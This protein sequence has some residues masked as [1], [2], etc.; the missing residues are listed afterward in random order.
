MGDPYTWI[1]YNAYNYTPPPTSQTQQQQQQQQQH[2]FY[3]SSND[4]ITNNSNTNNNTNS[5]NANTENG[6]L[7][8]PQY[9]PN[10]F[11][12][13]GMLKGMKSTIHQ[14]HMGGQTT[15]E[16]MD[17]MPINEQM[18]IEM[19][20][21]RIREMEENIRPMSEEYD[22]DKEQLMQHQGVY[23]EWERHDENGE[24]MNPDTL[25]S[26]G[27]SQPYHYGMPY[28]VSLKSTPRSSSS[29]PRKPIKFAKVKQPKMSDDTCNFGVRLFE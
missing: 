5:I 26:M 22:Y 24:Y 13:K 10:E 25:A 11:Y 12:P 17:I 15:P 23:N 29:I 7:L 3:N 1:P 19:G 9:N 4:T 16:H 2:P 8:E 20:G 18:M 21:D 27:S 28:H 14:Q 6:T